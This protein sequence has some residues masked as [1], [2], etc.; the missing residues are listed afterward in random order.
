MEFGLEPCYRVTEI[1]EYVVRTAGKPMT[2][3]NK[4]HGGSAYL[5][6]LLS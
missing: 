5:L 3:Y 6:L 2:V 1:L 4:A